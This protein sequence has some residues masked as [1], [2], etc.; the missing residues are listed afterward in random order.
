MLPSPFSFGKGACC[1]KWQGLGCLVTDSLQPKLVKGSNSPLSMVFSALFG[2]RSS[3]DV[4]YPH[5]A[6]GLEAAACSVDEAGVHALHTWNALTGCGVQAPPRQFK[7]WPW[8][9]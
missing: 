4:P 6:P 8:G 2:R 3:A 9:C 7:E 1:C 5:R